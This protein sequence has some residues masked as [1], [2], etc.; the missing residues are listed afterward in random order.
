MKQNQ[1]FYTV[2]CT[3][4]VLFAPSIWADPSSLSPP[5]ASVDILEPAD[6]AVVSSP[7][8]VKFG[9][10]NMALV[11]A[12]TPQEYSGHHHLLVDVETLPEMSLPIPADSHHLHFGKGQSETTLDLPPGKHSL[13]LLLGDYLHRPHDK[14]VMSKKITIT[15]KA[16]D[17]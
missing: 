6:G 5:N 13:Q 10:K 12:G 7:F 4:L 14:P 11:P 9:I 15:V 8:N 2:I 17:K 1:R 3:V 16:A